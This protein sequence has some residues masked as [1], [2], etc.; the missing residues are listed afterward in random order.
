M[1]ALSVV[2]EGE[3]ANVDAFDQPGVEAY[4]RLMGPRLKALKADT[5]R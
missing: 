5:K 2:Y 3:L 1:L 4:K